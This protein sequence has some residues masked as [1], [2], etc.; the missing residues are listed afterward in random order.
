[1]PRKYRAAII[2]FGGMGQRHYVA[3]QNLRVDVTA[4]CD[5]DKEKIKRVLPSYPESHIYDDYQKVIANEDFDVISVAT[6]GPSHAEIT[7]RVAEAGIK[8]ILCEKPMAT[9]LRDAEKEIQTCKE[10]NTRLAINHIRRW[11]PNHRKLKKLIGEGTIGKL[12]HIYFQCGSSGLGNLAIHFLDNM[13]FYTDNE[14]EWVIG[15]IDKTGTPNPR[16]PQFKDP[17]GYGI[18][19]FKNG[20]RGFIDTSE[21]TGV[22]HI[23]HLVGACGRV[24]IEE[25]GN[26]WKIWARNR[27]DRSLPLTRYIIPMEEVPFELGDK[28]DIVKLTSSAIKE[29]LKGDKISCDGE[30]GKKALEVVIAFHMSDSLNNQKIYLPL[31]G[32]ALDKDVRIA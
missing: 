12:R 14:V 23:C 32:D 15:F 25:W 22:R 9:N 18:L 2:G 6:N 1:M 21:D 30:A 17:G 29:L 3:Y 5:W 19:Q 13:R 4:I 8:N 11:S 10:N 7:I 26:C 31:G 27:E 16:G 28:F 24:I 20:V